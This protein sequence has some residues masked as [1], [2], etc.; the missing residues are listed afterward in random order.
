MAKDLVTILPIIAKISVNSDAFL[1]KAVR[2]NAILDSI[3]E[4]LDIVQTLKISFL[5]H[6]L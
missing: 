2:N 4:A 1:E 6:L 3:V 5:H